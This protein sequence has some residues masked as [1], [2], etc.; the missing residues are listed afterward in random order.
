MCGTIQSGQSAEVYSHALQRASLAGRSAGAAPDAATPGPAETG[1]ATPKSR[2][3][4][5]R[6]SL[7]HVF[8]DAPDARA[9]VP[10][11]CVKSYQI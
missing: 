3:S 6:P 11:V 2:A 9:T 7:A 5:G 8:R 4:S 1:P 10:V